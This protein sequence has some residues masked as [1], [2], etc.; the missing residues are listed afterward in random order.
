MSL[1]NSED[2]VVNMLMTFNAK[3]AEAEAKGY[4]LGYIQA[5]KDMKAY[6]NELNLQPPTDEERAD[7]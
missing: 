5:L 3:I 4:K 6:A 7:G 2:T 1:S